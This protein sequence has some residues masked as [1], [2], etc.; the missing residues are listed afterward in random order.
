MFFE[1]RGSKILCRRVTYVSGGNNKTETV[2]SFNRYAR[3]IPD[4]VR[5]ALTEEELKKLQERLDETDKKGEKAHKALS[6]G[7]I[8]S[9]LR[10]AIEALQ[11]AEIALK[12]T[13]KQADAIWAELDEMRR[14]LRQAKHPKPKPVAEPNGE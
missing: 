1:D 11:D 6:L 14:A 10:S 4:E 13:P 8:A 7:S 3:P 9:S 12:L 5:A 2:I